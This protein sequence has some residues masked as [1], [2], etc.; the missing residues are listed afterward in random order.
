MVE[1]QPS[2]ARTTHATHVYL[3]REAVFISFFGAFETFTIKLANPFQA[4]WAEVIH[5][6]SSVSVLD[7]YRLS[8]QGLQARPHTPLTGWYP[9]H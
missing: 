8:L 3:A 1:L 9:R 7:N 6:I 2:A 5:L 4:A